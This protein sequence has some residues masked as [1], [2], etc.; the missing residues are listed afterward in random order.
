[1]T[2][3]AESLET[4]GRLSPDEIYALFKFEEIKGTRNEPCGCPVARYLTKHTETPISVNYISARTYSPYTYHNLP[5][6]VSRFV[7]RFDEGQF[8][9]VEA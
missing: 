7:W 5:E 8:R 1:M 2:T 3:L 4:L 9:G 6:T